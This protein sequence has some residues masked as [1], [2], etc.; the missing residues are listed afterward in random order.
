[1]AESKY[2]KYVIREPKFVKEMA[3][4]DFERPP[5]GSTFPIEVYIDGE[6]I[7]GA[8]QY[9]TVAWIWEVPNPSTL[10][11]VHS[12]PFDEMVLFIGSNPRDMRDFGG[13][14][15][16]WMGEGNDFE[17]FMI[18]TTSLIY[19]PKG[20]VHGPLTYKR[21]DKPS[22]FMVIGLNTPGYH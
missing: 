7:R 11:G 10:V 5:T 19:I 21:V 14:V 8:N 22:L 15:E 4:H 20:L 18:N 16:M 3:L 9:V 2:G 12:H 1:M 13:E 17:K 6:M